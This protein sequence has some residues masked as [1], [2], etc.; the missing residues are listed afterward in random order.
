MGVEGIYRRTLR[1]QHRRPHLSAEPLKK[2]RKEPRTEDTEVFWG[3][4]RLT[5]CFRLPPRIEPP[6]PRSAAT[7]SALILKTSVPSVSSVET[8]SPILAGQRHSM[9]LP[10]PGLAEQ[11][12]ILFLDL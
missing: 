4:P 12:D 10:V 5:L 3:D 1:P 11:Q 9:L 7:P 2:R 6:V 8:S